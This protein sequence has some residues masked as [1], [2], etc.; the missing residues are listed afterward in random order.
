MKLVLFNI[1]GNKD[2]GTGHI[3]RSL[4]LAK[5]IK[6]NFKVT[7][8]TSKN[9]KLAIQSI[10]KTKY[11]LFYPS[12]ETIYDKKNNLKPLIVRTDVL[13]TTKK[14]IKFLKKNKRKVINFEG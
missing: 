8:L 3:Y 11:E 10:K 7:F 5:E 4:S 1:I 2:I 12:E 13:S 14:K 6:K 9:Q